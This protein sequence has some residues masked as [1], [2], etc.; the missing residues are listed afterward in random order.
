MF[1]LEPRDY[2]NNDH[3]LTISIGPPREKNFSVTVIKR[4]KWKTFSWKRIWKY[5]PQ[6]TICSSLNAEPSPGH[7]CY[8]PRIFLQHTWWDGRHLD[9]QFESGELMWP[10]TYTLNDVLVRIS[11][12]Q[13]YS[14]AVFV[15][16]S[17]HTILAIIC[18]YS[19]HQIRL[20]LLNQCLSSSC[21][22][23][24]LYDIW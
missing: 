1:C 8:V 15:W 13:H 7:L 14:L 16:I 21:S 17:M 6:N 24:K 18:K 23:I 11:L 3:V 5:C 10:N 12:H 2:L 20:W 9:P 22:I 19:F 4:I